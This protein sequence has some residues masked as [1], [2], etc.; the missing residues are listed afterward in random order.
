MNLNKNKFNQLSFL[1]FFLFG[2]AIVGENVALTMVVTVLGSS[3]LGNLY[4]VNGL[5]LLLLPIFF[6]QYI[7]KVNRGKLLSTELLSIAVILTCYLF[8]FLFV[9]KN[10]SGSVFMNILILVIYPISYLAKTLLFLTFWTMANDVYD[11]NDSKKGFP[12]IA[13]WGITGGLFGA[14][15]ARLLLVQ[16]KIELVIVLWIVAYLIG[17]YFSKKT[18]KKYWVHFLKKEEG[19][20]KTEKPNIFFNLENILDSRLVRYISLLYFSVFIAIFLQDYLFWKKSSNVFISSSSLASFQFTFYLTH[21]LI[22]VLGLRFFMPSIIH[23]WGFT[24][25]F[26]LTPVIL[27]AGSVLMLL[28]YMTG[29]NPHIL[30]SGFVFIQFCRYVVFENAFSPVYQMF[31]AAMPKEKVGRAKTFLEGIVKPSAI[32]VSGVILLQIGKYSNVIMLGVAVISLLMIFIVIK[33]RKTY[34]ESLIPH[35]VSIDAV[36]D[37][38]TKI[39]SYND[40]KILSLIKGYSR[41]SDVD[42]RSLSVK[43]LSHVGSRQAF[44]IIKDIFNTE[45]NHVVKEMIARS[46]TQFPSNE[47]KSFSEQLLNDSNPRIRANTLFSINNMDWPWQ[48]QLLPKVRTMMSNENN[49]RIRIES[50]RFLWKRGDDSDRVKIFSLIDAFCSSKNSNKRSAGIYLVG[51][52]KPDKWEGVLKENLQSASMQVFNKCVEIILKYASKKTKLETLTLIEGMSRR[53][54]AC[55][56]KILQ[57][58]DGMA[59]ETIKD[60]LRVARNQRMIVEVIHALRKV[61]EPYKSNADNLTIDEETKGIVI[62]WALNDLEQIYFD[63]FIWYKFVSNRNNK[64]IEE[65]ENVFGDAMRD[66]LFRVCERTLDV[67]ALCDNRRIIGAVYN[68]FDLRDSA[69][70][71]SLAE[72]LESLSDNSIIPFVL[73]ILRKDSW[74]YLAKTGKNKF[75][76]NID[77][78]ESE[79]YFL[80]RSKNKWVSFCALYAWFKLYGS[81]HLFKN[82]GKFLSDLQKEPNKYHSEAV[83]RLLKSSGSKSEKNE[84]PFELLE[85]TMSLKK[86]AMFMHIPAEKLMGLAEITQCRFYKSGTLISREGE[87]SDHL[88]IVGKGSLKI[89]K[90]KNNVKTILSIL[91]EGETYG[92]IGLF[93]KSPRSA[94]AIANEDCKLWVIQR[95][96]LKRFLLEMPEIA[97]NFLEIFSEKLRKSSD[98]VASLHMLCSTEKKEFL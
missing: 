80:L 31:F 71:L 16:V 17:W 74:E 83:L 9:E 72:I 98:E 77:V 81:D 36:E 97:Y 92:E 57:S 27:F 38:I 53:H 67:I 93:S 21:G 82:E 65:I 75:D 79:L 78:K 40:L 42:V 26:A 66:Q 20:R 29:A 39:G 18:I 34:L 85:R 59:L 76:F 51:E 89:I 61:I 88:Y 86:T 8:V 43:I 56:G 60:Y 7:D 15:I 95:S 3:I 63:V 24:R 94:S 44:K 25:I 23:K 12:I 5:L 55:T 52:F 32:I 50:A 35:F 90:T 58:I 70:R 14:C 49:P 2:G 41:S 84:E 48:K 45:S 46:L 10:Y 6:F 22:T 1:L 37:I 68:D 13:A 96:E 28:M 47:T 62:E 91:R 87:L 30:F 19:Y 64:D 11:T 33:L 73:P 4:L 69:Q 54:I